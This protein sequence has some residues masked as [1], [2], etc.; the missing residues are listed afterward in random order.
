MHKSRSTA[1][2]AMFCAAMPSS[3]AKA[4]ASVELGAT[5]SSGSDSAGSRTF[6]SQRS[7]AGCSQFVGTSSRNGSSDP[8]L[9][10]PSQRRKVLWRLILHLAPFKVHGFGICNE[11]P[12]TDGRRRKEEGSAFAPSTS[13]KARCVWVGCR[14]QRRQG[15]RS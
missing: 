5:C 11:G 3:I 13:Q 8:P 2:V 7:I 9:P 12:P 4:S 1:S 10:F 14:R 6:S 15:R